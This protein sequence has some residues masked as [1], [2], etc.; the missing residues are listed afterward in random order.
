M[1]VSV[2]VCVLILSTLSFTLVGCDSK[3]NPIEE[4][5][6]P[7]DPTPP[8]LEPVLPIE[9]TP[10]PVAP[11][12]PTEPTPVEPVPPVDPTPPPVEP[13]PPVECNT[14]IPESGIHFDITGVDY[15]AITVNDS[16]LSAG[17]QQ[18]AAQCA[19]CHGTYGVAVGETVE[20]WPSLWGSGRNIAGTMKDYNDTDYAY[21]AMHVHS[22]VSYTLDEIK[23]IQEYYEKVTY[24]GG[25]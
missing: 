22:T 21:S 19:Q 8:L 9:P 5:V 4:P 7:V 1:K 13:V 11:I 3:S 18:L 20:H 23:L 17:A 25:E 14:S 15:N 2:K 12:L 10:P 16:N 6:P 24:T